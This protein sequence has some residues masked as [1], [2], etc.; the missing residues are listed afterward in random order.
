V[1]QR[2]HIWSHLLLLR[3][4]KGPF[5]SPRLN[6]SK[7]A[8]WVAGMWT[9]LDAN[10]HQRVD[11]NGGWIRSYDFEFTT[12]TEKVTSTSVFGDGRISTHADPMSTR[13]AILIGTRLRELFPPELYFR[14]RGRF[15]RFWASGGAKFP[16][17]GDSL[18]RTT[19]TTEQYLT[20]LA[21]SSPEKSVTVQTNKR[22]IH[23]LPIGMCG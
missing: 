11:G 2:W 20:P 19:L 23:T 1:T 3:E 6:W 18:P 15:V 16:K 9:G 22:Y 17:M 12:T 13:R 10:L 7:L 21:L 8:S 5:S 4:S 14:V